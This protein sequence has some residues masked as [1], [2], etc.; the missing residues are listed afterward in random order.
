MASAVLT[1]W[2]AVLLVPIVMADLRTNAPHKMRSFLLTFGITALVIL[3]PTWI[4]GGL[5]GLWIP[6]RFHLSRGMNTLSLPFLVNDVGTRLLHVDLISPAI[7]SACFVAQFLPALVAATDSMN[8]FDRTVKW[9]VVSIAVF[10]VFAKFQS[11]QWILWISPL[12]LLVARTRLEIAWLICFD[13]VTYLQFPILF[14]TVKRFSPW[15]EV[16]SSLRNLMLIAIAVIL[17]CELLREHPMVQSFTR[18]RK[19]SIAG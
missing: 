5:A 19:G 3:L 9:S 16:V 13:L 17:G 2:F 14:D 11:P 8:S 18:H 15:L 1:K 6:Y 4:D 10:V 12:F 7:L